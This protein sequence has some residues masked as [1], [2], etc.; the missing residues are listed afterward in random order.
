LK[1][2]KILFTAVAV[3]DTKKLT[4]Q[5]KNKLKEMLFSLSKNPYIGKRLLGD[6]KGYYSLRLTLKDRVVYSIDEKLSTIYIHRTK[7]HYGN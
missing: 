2:Y 7:T 5:L 1:A 6:L 3:K 4:N